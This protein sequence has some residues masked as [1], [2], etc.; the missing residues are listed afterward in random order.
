[1][2][3]VTGKKHVFA[4]GIVAFD[5]FRLRRVAEL[6]ALKLF[7]FFVARR[8]NKTNLANIG[9]GKI[10]EY[11]NIKRV[12]IKTAI[13]FLASLSLVHVEHVRIE[14]NEYGISNAYRVVGMSPYNH[15]GTTGRSMIEIDV[16]KR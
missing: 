4:R 5:D 13:S 11:T 8:D 2:G 6:D 15:M 12:R 10:E 14:T 7:F 9:Y 1:M 16:S 3:K